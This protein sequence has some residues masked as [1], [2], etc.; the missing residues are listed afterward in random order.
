MWNLKTLSNGLKI[1]QFIDSIDTANQITI[2]VHIRTPIDPVELSHLV[3]HLITS[4]NHTMN[5]L[6][7][8]AVTRTD[9]TFYTW[10][11]T[12]DK[13]DTVMD[14]ICQIYR[15]DHWQTPSFQDLI[16]EECDI[17]EM[18]HAQTSCETRLRRIVEF[19][20][21]SNREFTEELIDLEFDVRKYSKEK[22]LQ[23]HKENYIPSKTSW[24]I[25]GT[26]DFDKFKNKLINNF[27]SDQD[28]WDLSI[29]KQPVIQTGI[30][31]IVKHNGS[32]FIDISFPMKVHVGHL[33][34]KGFSDYLEKFLRYQLKFSY[35]VNTSIVDYS[36]DQILVHITF[37]TLDKFISD[38]I[39]AVKQF[40]KEF[41]IEE[42]SFNYL[43]KVALSNNQNYLNNYSNLWKFVVVNGYGLIDKLDNNLQNYTYVDFLTEDKI[44]DINVYILKKY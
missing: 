12:E 26:I 34:V 4:D 28:I 13:F 33:L 39:T 19:D 29:T 9:G 30:T 11:C 25:R 27:V 31:Q 10:I 20:I 6:H 15:G 18:E 37:G 42:A 38:V 22:I 23:F 43:K 35:H 41:F 36:I 7:Q 14:K 8:S 17:I 24:V 16:D 3:E 32:T 21:E 1:Y 2:T 44:E 40:L 5:V